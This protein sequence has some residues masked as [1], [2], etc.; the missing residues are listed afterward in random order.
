MKLPFMLTAVALAAA[1]SS[2]SAQEISIGVPVSLTGVYAFVGTAAVKGL[3]MAVDEINAGS[4]A[5]PGRTLKLVIADDGSNTNQTI[6]LVN[7]LANVDKVMAIAGPSA[8]PTVLAVSPVV[9]QLQIPMLGI[10]VT[11]AVNKAGPWSNRVLN[12]P[13]TLMTVLANY[14][15]DTVKPKSI[16]TVASRD[17][18]GAAAQTKVIRSVLDGKVSFMPEESAM[19]AETDFSALSTKIA[20]LKPDAVMI[21]MNDSAAA[22]IILQ[23]RQAGAAP[24]QRFVA[25]N[26]AASASFLRI[27]GKAV[28]GT[29]IGTDAFPEIRSDA[30]AKTFVANFQ[31]KYNAVPDQWNAVGYTIGKLYGHALANVKGA[32]TRQSLNDAVVA[33]R[34]FPVVLGSGKG[35]FSFTGAER[36]PTYEPILIT[37]KDGKFIP[38]P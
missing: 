34:N 28:E 15:L 21:T 30:L 24:N 35:N 4:E 17:N 5:G 6:T 1:V 2:A 20:S 3:Q 29:L 16:M 36:E 9:N 27:G 33:T 10:A 23:A 31:K 37:V 25:N 8:S 18:D 12:S 14:T 7:R 13:T 22:N 19:M 11:Q 26:A 38:A 32:V